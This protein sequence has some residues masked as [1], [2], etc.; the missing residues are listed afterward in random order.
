MSVIGQVTETIFRKTETFKSHGCQV[1]KDLLAQR[2]VQNLIGLGGIL[3]QKGI[4]DHP[5][6]GVEGVK[7]P[8]GNDAHLDGVHLDLLQ[9]LGLVADGLGVENFD[10]PGA[11]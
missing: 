10:L 7:G 9:D 6:N 8:T 2:S 5:G 4:V 1:I 3:K 11:V